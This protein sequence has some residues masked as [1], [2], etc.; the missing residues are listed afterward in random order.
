MADRK[1]TGAQPNWTHELG[2]ALVVLFWGLTFLFT[3]MGLRTIPPVCF[4]FLRTLF[5]AA[6]LS[7]AAGSLRQ[8]GPTAAGWRT[9]A[10]AAL[11]GLCGM[12]L[13]PFAFSLAL[14]C[15]SAVDGGL[16]FGTTPVAVA[17]LSALFGM[18]QLDWAD[19]T[20]VVLS[21]LGILIVICPENGFVSGEAGT[22]DLL[23]VGAMLCWAVYTVGNRCLTA[24]QSSLHTTAYSSWWG[25]G[26]LLLL[27][28]PRLDAF[29]WE[30]VSRVSWI[31]AA[32]AGVL[33]TAASY[34]IWN[35]SVGC[36]GPAR[37]AVYLNLVPVVAALSG[38]L[39][40][41]EPLGLHHLAASATIMTGVCLTRSRQA[42]LGSRS[43]SGLSRCLQ[44]LRSLRASAYS[45]GRPDSG[46][47]DPRSL[48]QRS[49]SRT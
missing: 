39:A 19:W 44:G 26:G 45:L 17:A 11:L 38:Y 12:G 2:L 20:G 28:L 6:A 4:A 47:T 48:S 24:T 43:F 1:R 22:G 37:T 35:R 29:D 10:V 9:H 16:I 18:E 21:F 31:G 30:S 3:K 5:A 40:L 36:T 33:G 42:S 27:S 32:C 7:G 15:A 13:F 14:T 34:V 25:L 46:R 8:T 41:N 23:M 49:R